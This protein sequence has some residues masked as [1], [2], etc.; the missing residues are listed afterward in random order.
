MSTDY[1]LSRPT[2]SISAASTVNAVIASV[3][4][5]TSVLNAHNIDT[6]CGGSV[7]LAEAAARAHVDLPALITLLTTKEGNVVRT[8][9]D[10]ALPAATCACGCR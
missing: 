3:P 5:A 2:S 9:Q 10:V 8:G 7:T 4:A 6:C 1:P